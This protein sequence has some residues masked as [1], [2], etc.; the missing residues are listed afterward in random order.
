MIF[1]WKRILFF[2]WT[3]R[4]RFKNQVWGFKN[5]ASNVETLHLRN[6]QDDITCLGSRIPNETVIIATGIL[7]GGRY[8]Q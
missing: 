5:K 3:R 4:T 7:G 1:G 6:H 2:F 8:K